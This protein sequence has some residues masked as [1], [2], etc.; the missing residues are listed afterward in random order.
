MIRSTN[1]KQRTGL[2]KI[3]FGHVGRKHSQSPVQLSL[4]RAGTQILT[5]MWK[6]QCIY[7]SEKPVSSAGK[8]P[9]T[10][11]H[12]W[13]KPRTVTPWELLKSPMKNT[14]TFTRSTIKKTESHQYAS[15][16]INGDWKTLGDDNRPRCIC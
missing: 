12:V 1:S 10:L 14:R 7:F 8:K 4:C 6:L 2:T 11:V 5:K 9:V 13:I 15:Y 16:N 3:L